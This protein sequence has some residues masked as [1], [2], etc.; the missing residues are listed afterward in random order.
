MR[1]FKLHHGAK[2]EKDDG[3]EFRCVR[4]VMCV[5]EVYRNELGKVSLSIK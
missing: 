5:R 3:N 1:H 2:S 4:D